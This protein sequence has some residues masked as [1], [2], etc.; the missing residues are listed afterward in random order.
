MRQ[1]YK[2][3]SSMISNMQI[4]GGDTLKDDRHIS[5]TTTTY[6]QIYTIEL[7]EQKRLLNTPIWNVTILKIV[8]RLQQ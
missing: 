6:N 5:P 2:T 3:Y 1:L 8:L 4:Y 7:Y